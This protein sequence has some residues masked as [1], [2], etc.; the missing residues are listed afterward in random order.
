MPPAK[1]P[2]YIKTMD[3]TVGDNRGRNARTPSEIPRQGWRDILW[4]VWN[5]IGEDNLF[6]VA[7]GVSFYAFLALFPA[8]AAMVSLAG[9]IME[10]ADVERL[11]ASAT[12]VL[13]PEALQII[14]DQ[15]REVVSTSN[16]ALGIGLV[17]SL[18]L[19]LWSATAGV[20]ALMTALNIVY[21]EHESRGFLRYYA[22]AVVLTLGAIIFAPT[23]LMLVAALPVLLERL[24]PVLGILLGISRWLVLGG[25]L[26]LVLAVVY[27]YA[28]SRERAQWRWVTWGSALA[29]VLWLIGSALFSLYVAKFGD[30]N[31]TYGALGAIV[32]LLTWFY[33]TTVV[34]LLGAELNAEMEHQTRTDSTVGRPE[35]MGRRGA[36]MADTLGESK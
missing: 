9:L 12:G 35:P 28:P 18:T 27:R 10:P 7:A 21:D 2:G 29:M 22:T 26:L 23:A 31:K 4:R 6:L 14:R 36:Q 24:P 20:K 3:V 5:Q 32:I 19:A 11:V 15:V 25:A 16:E 30:Y 13:P 17:V 34:I 1:A 33:L 8:L